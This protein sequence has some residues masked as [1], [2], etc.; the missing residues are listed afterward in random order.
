[1][2]QFFGWVGTCGGGQQLF[3]KSSQRNQNPSNYNSTSGYPW[4]LGTVKSLGFFKLG[5]CFSFFLKLF[6]LFLMCFL[7]LL[8]FCIIKIN[9]F[10]HFYKDII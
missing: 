5:S 6:F 9:C 2:Q 4:P 10:F 3:K 8:L 7:F 1:L